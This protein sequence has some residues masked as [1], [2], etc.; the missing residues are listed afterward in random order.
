[1]DVPY[2]N[3]QG[4]Y[5]AFIATYTKL[6]HRPPAEADIQ[7]YF[8]VTPPSVHNMILT[9]ERRGFISRTP[10]A[11][12]S[13]RLLVEPPSLDGA[14]TDITG[15]AAPRG[16]WRSTA[17][18]SSGRALGAVE[19]HDGILTVRGGGGVRGRNGIQYKGGLSGKNA[20]ARQLSM[21]VAAIPREAWPARTFTW[22]SR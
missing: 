15:R 19:G 2:T 13:I 7:A 6:H 5:L 14:S 16:P 3:H 20:G 21:N 9:I 22:A 12:R 10:G 1:M 17:A 18:V 8:Q 11:P 4:R